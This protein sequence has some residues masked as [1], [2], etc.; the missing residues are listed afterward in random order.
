MPRLTRVS[1]AFI[2]GCGLKQKLTV[3]RTVRYPCFARLYWRVRIETGL[4]LC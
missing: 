4:A 2:G 3:L 1:P